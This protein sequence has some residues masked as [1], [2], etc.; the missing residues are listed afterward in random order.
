MKSVLPTYIMCDFCLTSKVLPGRV[1]PGLQL[2][3]TVHS[4]L[5]NVFLMSKHFVAETDFGKENFLQTVFPSVT[6]VMLRTTK[7][8]K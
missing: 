6:S 2:Q 8:M 5:Q 7:N 4:S 3:N 1:K